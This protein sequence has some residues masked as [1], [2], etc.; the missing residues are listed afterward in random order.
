MG[1]NIQIPQQLRE[2]LLDD[3]ETS[4]ILPEEPDQFQLRQDTN[5]IRSP[6]LGDQETVH[7][8][9]QNLHRFCQFRCMRQRNQW[10]FLAK[11][12]DIFQWDRLSFST[13]CGKLL[14]RRDLAL[15]WVGKT[16]NQQ[17]ISIQVAVVEGGNRSAGGGGVAD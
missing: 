1:S 10:L 13:L 15:I 16:N 5:Y 3:R 7:S 8:A 9:A 17:Q 11:I 14:E 4:S 6:F 2:E 12:F